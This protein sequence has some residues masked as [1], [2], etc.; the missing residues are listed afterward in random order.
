MFHGVMRY[1][2]GK[3]GMGWIVM[4]KMIYSIMGCC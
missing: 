3:A 4:E 1:K 2:D